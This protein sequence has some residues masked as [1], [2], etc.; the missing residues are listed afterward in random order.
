MV[1]SGH[2]IAVL[3]II[4]L[5]LVYGY[6]TPHGYTIT[7]HNDPII[8]D[9]LHTFPGGGYTY[10]SINSSGEYD[11]LSFSNIGPN[12]YRSELAPI[13]GNWTRQLNGTYNLV[14][15]NGFIQVL[16]YSS[17]QDVIFSENYEKVTFSRFNS[18]ANQ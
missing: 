2:I 10:I 13:H 17:S 16:N 5:A 8:G 7:H 6:A 9:W 18:S 14:H 3:T 15:D 12:G 11:E 1:E 4:I